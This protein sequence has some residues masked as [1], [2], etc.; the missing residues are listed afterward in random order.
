MKN[1][2]ALDPLDAME[3]TETTVIWM[4][5]AGATAL[6]GIGT[7]GTEVEIGTVD[8]AEV[9][10]TIDVDAVGVGVGANLGIGTEIKGILVISQGEGTS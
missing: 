10:A 3:G 4:I 6:I 7:S 8:V 2:L 9:V 5:G 1:G